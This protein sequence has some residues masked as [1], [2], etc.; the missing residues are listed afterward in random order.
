MGDIIQFD[1]TQDHIKE[2]IDKT[3]KNVIQVC[4]KCGHKFTEETAKMVE[5]KLKITC[6]K[7]GSEDVKVE[8]KA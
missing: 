7:C 2:L 3:R 6:P 4:Q 5:G 1:F 8:L